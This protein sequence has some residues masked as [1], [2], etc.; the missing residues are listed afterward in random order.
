M[1]AW[2]HPT[3]LLAA[4]LGFAVFSLLLPFLSSRPRDAIQVEMQ[5]ALPR[6]AQLVMAGGDRFLAA[7]IAGFRALLASTEAMGPENYRIQARVQADAAWFN[8]AHEDNYYIAA[9]ILPWN[10]QLEAAQGIL[11]QAS[12]ARPF[13]PQPAFYHGFN[14]FHFLKD[15]ATGSQ[16]LLVA[17][18]QSGDEEPRRQ[19]QALAARWAAK[20]E[21]REF[22]IRLH[23]AMAKESGHPGF[24]AY[25]EDQARELEKRLAIGAAPE[26]ARP[27]GSAAP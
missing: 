25:L 19:F 16:W 6:L 4:G 13:D 24:A 26:A 7:N 22:A 8:P 11:R 21:D 10:G 12:G 20:G 9:A 18:G 1:A 5:V 23:R 2:R 17:A 15:P 27:G 14:A 3:G